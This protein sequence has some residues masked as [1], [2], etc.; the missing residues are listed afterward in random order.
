MLCSDGISEAFDEAGH[1]FGAHRVIDVIERSHAKPSK[2]IVNDVFT[3]VQSFA[4]DAPQSDDR[5][6]VVVKITQLGPPQ[7]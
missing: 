7:K 4:G 1:E 6:V 5:T 2:E 3:A